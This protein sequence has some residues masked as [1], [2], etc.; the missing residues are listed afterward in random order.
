[1]P[2]VARIYIN[3]GI[4]HVL[5]RGNNKQWIF[6]DEEDFKVYTEVSTIS[7]EVKKGNTI[8]T[9]NEQNLT[10]YEIRQGNCVYRDISFPPGEM[11]VG[12]IYGY[13]GTENKIADLS[14]D[15]KYEILE[16]PGIGMTTGTCTLE[17]FKAVDTWRGTYCPA[18]LTKAEREAILEKGEQLDVANDE[19]VSG[20]FYHD[21]LEYDGLSW[22]GVISDIS[23]VRCD[24]IPEVAYED[25]GIRLYGGD[26][27]WDI[28]ASQDNLDKHNSGWI[29]SITP[30][31]QR[32]SLLTTHIE[33]SLYSANKP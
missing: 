15:T 3:E 1:M 2:R 5:T 17:D 11:H 23:A 14:D 29:S 25:A 12:I 21:V 4:F 18:G 22:G 30:S 16:H 10:V 20:P 32:S 27:W 8:V 9:S 33:D 26:T 31:K 7:I 28:M 24:G 6:H 13:T 19:Y